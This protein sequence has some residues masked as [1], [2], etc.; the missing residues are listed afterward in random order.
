MSS[1]FR[2]EPENGRFVLPMDEGRVF[3][4]YTRETDTLLITHVEADPK[5]RGTGAADRFMRELVGHAR[6]EGL[7]LRPLCSYAAAW[8]TRH[9]DESKDVLGTGF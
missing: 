2:H 8:M 6:Q 9:P 1:F 4:D 5:L 7:K 3:A